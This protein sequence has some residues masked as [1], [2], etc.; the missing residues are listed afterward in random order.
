ML[1]YVTNSRAMLRYQRIFFLIYFSL[2]MSLLHTKYSYEKN[3]NNQKLVFF[4]T[5]HSHDPNHKQY[6]ELKDAFKTF[7]KNNNTKKILLLEGT[8]PTVYAHQTEEK[9]IQDGGDHHF[10]YW[11]GQKHTIETINADINRNAVINCLVEQYSLPLVYAWAKEKITHMWNRFSNPVLPCDSYTNNRLQE[12]FKD[13]NTK[14]LKKINVISDEINKVNETFLKLR[15]KHTFEVIKQWW[16][17]GY[18][19]FIVHGF[20]HAQAHEQKIKTVLT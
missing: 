20:V 1:P 19:I 11:L 14:Q 9:I 18:S 2:T 17:K 5:V 13:Q 4:G 15:Q 6:S 12:W 10:A 7:V 8:L 16:K 3:K